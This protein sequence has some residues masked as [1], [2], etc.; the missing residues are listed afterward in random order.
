MQIK[1]FV[2][3]NWAYII[4]FLFVTFITVSLVL[5][6]KKENTGK[7]KEQANEPYRMELLDQKSFLERQDRI[8][9]LLHENMPLYLVVVSV[10][11]ALVVLFFVGIGLFVFFIYRSAKKTPIFSRTVGQRTVPWGIGDVAR[12]ALL[13][14]S[15]AYLFLFAE[16]MCMK[17]FPGMEDKNGLLILNATVT[18]TMGILFVLNFVITAYK[19][20]LETCG[21]TLKN[22]L[23]NVYYGIASYIGIIPVLFVTLAL[24]SVL[25]TVFKYRPPVQPIVDMLI[26]EEKVPVLVYSS[27]FAAVAGPIMEEIFFR[28]FMYNAFKKRVGILRGI[29]FT[30]AVFSLLHAHWVGFIPIFILGAL[31]AYLYEKTGSLVPSI[32][33]HILHNLASLLMVF[34]VKAVG[35]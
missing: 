35:V 20:K 14:F 19:E 1:R 11:L 17:A 15:F 26:K 24:T 12:F 9:K 33:V 23:R 30:A 5:A 16:D 34:I 4:M 18:D 7:K 3:N 2:R 22:F 21:I 28:G 8:N 31:L 13:F 10:N 27:V 29:L 25:I 32:T 6:D